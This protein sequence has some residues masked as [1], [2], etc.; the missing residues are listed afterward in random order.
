MIRVQDCNG[1]EVKVG[2]RAVYGAPDPGEVAAQTVE[3]IAISEPDVL[4]NPETDADD[5]GYAVDITIRFPDGDTDKLQAKI[6][7]SSYSPGAWESDADEV[8]EESGDLEVFA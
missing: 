6:L 5:G 4:Y 8:F 3:V 7:S 1:R 2:T